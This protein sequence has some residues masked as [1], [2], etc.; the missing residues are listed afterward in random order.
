MVIAGARVKLW[1]VSK[2]CG[3]YMPHI[4]KSIHT[5]FIIGSK[6]F[7]LQNGGVGTCLIAFDWNSFVAIG[8]YGDMAWHLTTRKWEGIHGEVDRCKWWWSPLSS[9][10][11]C[12]R[13]DSEG[14]YL[15]SLPDLDTGRMGHACSSFTSSTGEQVPSTCQHTSWPLKSFRCTCCSIFFLVYTLQTGFA[16]CWRR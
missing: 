2:H 6:L 9:S 3:I 13:Y 16:G 7:P 4:G 12:P 10:P 11:R 15:G 14:N 8:G 1:K 5:W